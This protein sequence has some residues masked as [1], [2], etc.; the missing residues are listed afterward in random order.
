MS[1]PS[2]KILGSFSLCMISVSAIL[3]L[4]SL[5][6]MASV[7]WHAISF[8]FLAGL[9]FLL[10]S[11]LVCAELSTRFPENG[12]IYTWVRA[13][14]GDQIGLS[15][16]WMEWFNNVVAFPTTLAMIVTTLAYVGLP[17]LASNK[18]WLFSLMMAVFW[19]VSIYHFF[20]V[21]AAR[22]LSIVGALFG[23]L[24]PA[25]AIILLAG[26]WLGSANPSQIP[27]STVLP[28]FSL[29]SVVFFVAVLSSYSGM[30]VTA[31]HAKD[32]R[33]PQT[34][35]PRAIF[36]A[37]LLI[38]IFSCLTSLAIATVVPQA[39]INLIN[40]VIQTFTYFFRAFDLSWLTPILAILIVL[41]S[42]ASLSAWVLAPARGMQYAA[43]QKQL[44]QVLAYQNRFDMPWVV[45]LVQAVLTSLLASIFLFADQ[46]KQAFW[47]LLA[48][49]SQFTVLVYI[50]VFIAAIV[51]R[52]RQ[53]KRSAGFH[54]PGPNSVMV[55]ICGLGVVA[56]FIGFSL[57][58]LAPSQLHFTKP[59]LFSLIMIVGDALIIAIPWL[60][61]A[62]VKRS[63]S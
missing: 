61:L 49:T 30:Q 55:L 2:Q 43:T 19:G 57:G 50:L 9:L 14:F 15:A 22:L 6:L 58:L 62:C 26:L 46:A 59:W 56:C 13:A 60:Y 1:R 23:T 37:G 53:G 3:S 31:F 20:G 39:K 51:L 10:P 21:R 11:G 4:R 32:V 45:L 7:G 16:M 29:A 52:F 25:L 33:S 41:G 28:Q 42:L 12:G 48:L 24:L 40:G 35:F 17:Q 5:P 44:P 47:L 54:I 27:H 8:Y 18:Y 38:F 36:F 34:S 63:K